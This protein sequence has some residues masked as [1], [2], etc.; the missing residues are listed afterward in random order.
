[1]ARRTLPPLNALR[2]FEAFA[3][4]GRMTAA[5]EELCV[6]HGAISRQIK[7]LEDVLGAPLVEG[8]R[9]RLKIT[10]AGLRLAEALTRA[11]DL[12]EEAA[13]R[14]P[15]PAS[16]PVELSCL[17]T[18]AM[19]WLIPRLPAF[20]ERHPQIQVRISESNR[21]FDFRADG[22]DAAIRMR[23]DGD[24]SSDDAEVT[25]FM[26]H[27][28]GPVLSPDLAAG[29]ELDLERLASLPRLS[30]RT[31][32]AGWEAWARQYGVQLPPAAVTREFDHSFYM[33]EA[34]IAGLGVAIGAWPF[35]LRELD[36]GRLI[37]PLGFVRAPHRYVVLLPRS[38]ARPAA[39]RLRDWLVEEGARTAPPK[40]LGTGG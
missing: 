6:T 35:V 7:H 10:E 14:R 1:M 4:Q 11:F 12:I 32:P 25:P 15:A 34:A 39:R 5:A 20:H 26:D 3:R 23:P 30:T 18:T 8:P 17:G 13:P 36:A 22:L 24:L 33:I 16:G 38:G 28:H 29:G 27:F 31:F 21:D 2:A 9:N 40:Q 37:A 19:K